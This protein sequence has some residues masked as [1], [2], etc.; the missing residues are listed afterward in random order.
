MNLSI[1]LITTPKKF[2]ELR[3]EWKELMKCCSENDYYSS[4]DWFYPLITFCKNN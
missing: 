4:Y 2:F 1:F 3:G